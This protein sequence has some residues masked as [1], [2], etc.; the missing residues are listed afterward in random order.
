MRLEREVEV[1]VETGLR[2]GEVGEN[3][4]EGVVM[5]RRV[6]DEVRGICW[7]DS[8]VFGFLEDGDLVV[9]LSR[10]VAADLEVWVS[11]TSDLEN[12]EVCGLAVDVFGDSSKSDALKQKTPNF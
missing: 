11:A 8:V 5:N 2:G 6:K 3:P 4:V 1:W 12:E 7:G 10:G 9:N